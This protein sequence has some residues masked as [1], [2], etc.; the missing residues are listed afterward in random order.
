[1]AGYRIAEQSSDYAGVKQRW[2]IIESKVASEQTDAMFES[3][4]RRQERHLRKELKTITKR[5]YHCRED[6]YA[7]AE[8]FS[9][10]LKLH[11]LTRAAY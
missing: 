3:N 7:A 1:M 8:G 10:A 5:A 2:L 4:L 6:A 11:R 9:K